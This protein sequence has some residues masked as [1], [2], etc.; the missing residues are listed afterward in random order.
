MSINQR[1]RFV[2]LCVFWLLIY[3][4]EHKLKKRCL[5]IFFNGSFLAVFDKTQRFFILDLLMYINNQRIHEPISFTVWF[6]YI[7]YCFFRLFL[8]VNIN[9]EYYNQVYRLVICGVVNISIYILCPLFDIIIVAYIFVTQSNI[10]V[11]T[12]KH[13]TYLIKNINKANRKIL[14]IIRAMDIDIHIVNCCF[15]SKH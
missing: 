3:I 6:I 15:V 9:I 10:D 12:W 7:F 13:C 2:L 4:N 14:S 5:T 11:L 1:L 8:F